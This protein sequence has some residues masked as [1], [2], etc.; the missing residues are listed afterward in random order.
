MTGTRARL[1]PLLAA[2]ADRG[3][4]PGWA[5]C[6][7]E[8]RRHAER[9]ADLLDSWAPE[10]GVSG[11]RRRVWRAAGL[12]HD[13]LRE[14][15]ADRLRLLAALDWPSP[16]LHG[17]ACAERLRRGGVEDRSLLRAVAFHTVGH[18]EFDL[19][20]HCLYL[21]DFLEPGRE[22]LAEERASLRDRMPG[23]LAAVRRRVLRLRIGHLL[24]GRKPIVPET[25]A[26]WNRCVQAGEDASGGDGA[27][28]GEG[29]SSSDGGAG[30]DDATGA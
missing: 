18:P 12:L 13:A 25:V 19:L 15:S 22:F 14:E 4:L 16:A 27:S 20:G 8:R 11:E 21:A 6:G 7:A 29:T 30:G 2:A 26:Y 1:H 10:L 24:D 9:V 3:E 17:P 5:R 28:R 23:D